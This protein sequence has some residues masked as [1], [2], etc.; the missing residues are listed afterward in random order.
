M[1]TTLTLDDD[2]AAKLVAAGRKSGQ[3]FKTVVNETLRRGLQGAQAARQSAPFVVEAQR[4]GPLKPGASL[5]RIS[6]LLEDIDG[7]RQG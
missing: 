6:A 7:P 1:R 4:M 2:V 3:P 5:D